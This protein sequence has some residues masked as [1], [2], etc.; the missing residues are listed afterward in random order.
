M[1]AEIFVFKVQFLFGHEPHDGNCACRQW[2][3]STHP[4]RMRIAVS[5]TG[6]PAVV[7]RWPV[8][9]LTLRRPLSRGLPLS[10]RRATIAASRRGRYQ[11]VTD[12][13]DSRR[14]PSRGMTRH[15]SSSPL[16]KIGWTGFNRPFR[17]VRSRFLGS[18]VLLA[19]SGVVPFARGVPLRARLPAGSVTS[20]LPRLA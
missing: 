18:S 8:R 20:P 6:S 17:Q 13:P 10:V 2:A 14:A 7:G 19:T 16:P 4:A 12:P 3:A 9:P 1:A 15:G 11:A 5:T